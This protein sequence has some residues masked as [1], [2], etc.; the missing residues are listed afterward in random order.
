MARSRFVSQLRKASP[1]HVH[2]RTTARFVSCMMALWFSS[3]FAD[4]WP[5]WGGP[6]RDCIWRETGIVDK[7][8][9][10]GLLPRRWS[11]AVGEGY[12]G[13][14]VAD[15][16]VVLT[17][18]IAQGQLERI[19]CFDAETGEERWQHEYAARYTINYPAGPRATPV[20][21]SGRV[22]SIGAVGHMFCQELA[23]G[24]ILWS[25]EFQRDFDTEL[26]TWGMAAS[27]LVDGDHL[28]TLV[29]GKNNALIVCFNKITGEEVWRSLEDRDVGYCP[30]VIYEFGG[31]RQLITWHPSAVSS[32]DPQDGK[33]IW[34][35]PWQIRFGL[36][37]PA[38]QKT[39]DRLFLTSFYNGPIMLQ[40]SANDA[41]IL[42]KGNSDSEQE[43]DKLHSI[44]PT[45]VVTPTHIFG[46]CSYGQ[47]RGLK[48]ETGERLWETRDAT[49]DGR[50]WN[51]FLIPHEDRYFLH[52]EQGDLIIAQLDG[53]GYHEI[54]RARLVEPT[55][56][57]QRRMTI[58]S[59]PAFAMKSVFARN[60][61][62]LVRVDLS[63]P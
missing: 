19:R 7:L 63:A 11:V 23:T 44:M 12:S 56:Q 53:T 52:N 60:D 50:W 9:T 46:V 24:R 37:I 41:Q 54:S 62:E 40:V 14:A 18:R 49:G 28:I 2:T 13:P 55:R 35:V 16:A 4:D 29:G 15:G 61:K 8:P 10:T 42:W 21:D 51:A 45:P 3:V 22:Y 6:Q 30:P 27:P 36:T 31:R 17:D 59:H 39:G 25:K 48:T 5:Q 58:W 20:I 34:E 57:V 43:T 26:P 32:L 47:L 38:P 33:V 1:L